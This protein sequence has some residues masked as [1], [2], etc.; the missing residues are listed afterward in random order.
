MTGTQ[1]AALIRS[2]TSTNSSTLTDANLVILANA[3]KDNLA[4]LIVA[5]VDE[6]YFNAEDTRDLEA[7]VRNYTVPADWLKSLRHIEAKLDG[8]KFQ[9]LDEIDYGY[10]QKNL[11]PLVE[12]NIVAQFSGRRPAFFFNSNELYLLSGDAITD[13]TDGLRIVSEIYPE[14]IST[15]NLSSG[16]DLSVASST[17]S[18]RLPRSTHMTWAKMV[19]IAYKSS[20]DKPLPLTD[21]E[22]KLAID[23]EDMYKK[24]R[25]RNAVREIIASVPYDD[26][27]DY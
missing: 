11:M 1:F 22:K 25:G 9:V 3:E 19:S 7:G 27:Q 6:G 16:T 13:V 20:K 26:G 4:E 17:L 23:L 21:A 14:D 12:S 24:L 2:W 5:N 18:V 15:S 10:I 8:S